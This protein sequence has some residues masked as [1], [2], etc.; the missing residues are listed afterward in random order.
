[1][2]LTKHTNI[3]SFTLIPS[4]GVTLHRRLKKKQEAV[5]DA[6]KLHEGMLV[7]NLSPVQNLNL[8]K[9]FKIDRKNW[10]TIGR[11]PSQTLTKSNFKVQFRASKLLGIH[12]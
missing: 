1:M 10:K 6:I 5:F 8:L 7:R 11:L 4:I 9:M 12:M 2:I 3:Y